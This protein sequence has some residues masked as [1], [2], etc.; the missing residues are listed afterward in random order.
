[1]APRLFLPTQ[2]YPALYTLGLA[3]F[4][5]ACGYMR[6]QPKLTN[7]MNVAGISAALVIF[8][9]ELGEARDAAVPA[10]SRIQQV[11]AW[12]HVDPEGGCMCGGS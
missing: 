4:C 10:L 2:E 7:A 12:C 11:G 6:V 1:M 9:V 5:F 8:S 3:V